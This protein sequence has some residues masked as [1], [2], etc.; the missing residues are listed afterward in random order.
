M[1]VKALSIMPGPEYI[2]NKCIINIVWVILTII[3][4][5]IIA[6]DWKPKRHLIV[7]SENKLQ[8]VKSIDLHPQEK[9]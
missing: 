7:T 1:H 2:H 4:P 3:S 5:N 6:R 8:I 9:Y